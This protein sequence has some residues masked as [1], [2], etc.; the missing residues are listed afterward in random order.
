MRVFVVIC[1]LFLRV[2][3]PAAQTATVEIEVRAD[4][5]PAGVVDVF[6]NGVARKTDSRGQLS[7]TLPAGHLDIVVVK[8][9]FAPASVSVDV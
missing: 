6:V 1:V 7:L 2:A 5:E 9:G 8:G 4:A 3:A